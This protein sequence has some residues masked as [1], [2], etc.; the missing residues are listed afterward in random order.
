MI[1]EDNLTSDNF[2][3]DD[4]DKD[5]I[6]SYFRSNIINL[7]QSI[8]SQEFRKF[9][10][11]ENNSERVSFIL[12]YQ[13]SHELSIEVDNNEFKNSEKAKFLKDKGNQAFANEKYQDAIIDYSNAALLAPKEGKIFL[14]RIKNVLK[15]FV[16]FNNKL[17]TFIWLFNKK[18]LIF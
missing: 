10:N 12:K 18:N 14:C 1:I 17:T 3:E 13:E 11:L 15:R 7:R 8:G 4:M 9:A 2:N 6:S 16:F 5:E